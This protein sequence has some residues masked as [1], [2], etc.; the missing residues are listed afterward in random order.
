MVYSPFSPLLCKPN[1]YNRTDHSS[2]T[3]EHFSQSNHGGSAMWFVHVNHHRAHGWS[4]QSQYN[5]QGAHKEGKEDAFNHGIGY[6]HVKENVNE[7]QHK[8]ITETQTDW[9]ICTTFGIPIIVTIIQ[10]YSQSLNLAA[11]TLPIPPPKPKNRMSH[12]VY[13][14]FLPPDPTKSS[15]NSHSICKI[16]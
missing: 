12:V 4:R 11:I 7:R 14:S 13:T 8:Q 1:K 3:V 5:C 10:P 2:Q 9:Q 15:E 6:F 16:S